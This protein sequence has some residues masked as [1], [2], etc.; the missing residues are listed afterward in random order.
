MLGRAGDHTP[1]PIYLWHGYTFYNKYPINQIAL[2]LVYNPRH[3]DFKIF[4]VYRYYFEDKL[5]GDGG[6]FSM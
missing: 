3:K 6:C 5:K 1:P 4:I 2:Y